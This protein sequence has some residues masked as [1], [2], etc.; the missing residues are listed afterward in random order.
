MLIMLPGA[1]RLSR[2]TPKAYPP[3]LLVVASGQSHVIAIEAQVAVLS[4][5]MLCRALG[6]AWGSV[7]GHT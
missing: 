7:G 1:P 6:V 3:E 5:V 4:P 2:P